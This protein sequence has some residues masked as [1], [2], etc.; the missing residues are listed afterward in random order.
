[1]ATTESKGKMPWRFW[2]DLGGIWALEVLALLVG[3]HVLPDHFEHVQF[4]LFEMCAFVA[5]FMGWDLEEWMLDTL[6]AA[7]LSYKG[8]ILDFLKFL[9]SCVMYTL[10]IF[11]ALAA[12]QFPWM[13]GVSILIF[14]GLM[15]RVWW[16]YTRRTASSV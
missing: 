14:L 13:L 11:A 12:R 16:L 7:A 9:G 8:S 1:M 3:F 15:V 10:P 5:L 4:D 2:A 6:G